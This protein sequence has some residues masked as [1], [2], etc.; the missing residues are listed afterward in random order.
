MRR[1]LFILFMICYICLSP[2]EAEN[3]FINSVR[4]NFY[5]VHIDDRIEIDREG[6]LYRG[7][8]V[9]G[10]YELLERFNGMA[11]FR[12]EGVDE[13]MLDS[14]CY[15]KVK[16]RDKEIFVITV[17]EK[18][19]TLEA[20]FFPALVDSNKTT[21]ETFDKWKPGFNLTLFQRR[22]KSDNPLTPSYP[23]FTV[24]FGLEGF[25]KKGSYFREPRS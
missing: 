11:L 24:K 25:R 14:R 8:N 3:Y 21:K 15:I 23:V 6:K 1:L 12:S 7:K 20:F 13:A 16:T 10:K 18:E 5:I 2:L 17:Q 22:L 9:I 4:F 19:K